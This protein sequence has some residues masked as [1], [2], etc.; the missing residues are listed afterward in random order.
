MLR[1][2]VS[3]TT[4]ESTHTYETA[5]NVLHT[6]L[7]AP[8]GVGQYRIQGGDAEDSELYFRTG[9]RVDDEQMPP[10][11][12]KIVDESGHALL[13]QWIDSLPPPAATATPAATTATTATTAAGG[14]T[15]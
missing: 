2:S 9:V 11:A 1:L 3:D 7:G 13:R 4:V 10:I 15:E 12:T 6:W 5:V 14:A 8:A